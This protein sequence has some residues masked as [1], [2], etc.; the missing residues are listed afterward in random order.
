[1][2]EAYEIGISLA[3]QDGVSDGIALIRRD[4]AAL[5]R[6]IAATSQSL[7]RLQVQAG[8]PSPVH[9]P[10]ATQPKPMVQ[11]ASSPAVPE[12]QALPATPK[13]PVH[14]P[15]SN[16]PRPDAPVL[17]IRSPI[18]GRPTSAME[19]SY[20]EPAA[21]ASA[22]NLRCL[23]IQS[24]IVS[25]GYDATAVEYRSTSGELSAASEPRRSPGPS[26]ACSAVGTG[27]SV[28]ARRGSDRIQSSRRPAH[29]VTA[30]PGC[31]GHALARHSPA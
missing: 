19:P 8:T 2:L 9:V 24:A 22:G 31:S 3:L 28:R 23:D 30:T 20:T 10:S 25:I 12:Q 27:R 13:D 18:S 11:A 5:D 4:L 14:P 7:T 21:E 16:Q 26:Q 6:A 15:M 1:M 29:S 17:D